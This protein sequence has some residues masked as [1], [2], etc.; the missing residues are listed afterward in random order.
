MTLPVDN[1]S[2]TLEACSVQKK[3]I[4]FI[5]HGL[6]SNKF[7]SLLS[8]EEKEDSLDSV[9]ETDSMDF[10]TLSGKRIF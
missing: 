3:G 5:E 7:V 1:T 10:M 2:A 6:G 4:K 9:V 8:L